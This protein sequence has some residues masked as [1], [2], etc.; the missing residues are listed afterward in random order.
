M[1][2]Q[3]PIRSFGRMRGR[4]LRVTKQG[5]M[6]DILP[7]YTLAMP[8]VV[9]K[10]TWLEIGFGQGE[11]LAMQAKRNP[12]VQLIGCEPFVNGIGELL[13]QIEQEHLDNI[14]IHT[15]DAREVMKALPNA[16]LSRAFI[17]FPDPWPKA[18]H[19]KRRIIQQE[20]LA[21]MARILKPGGSLLIATDHEDYLT[22][23]LERIQ[24]QSD[25]I[26][27]A[28]C[29][30]DWAEPPIDWVTTKYQAKAIREGRKPHWL[31]LLRA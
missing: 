12:D 28:Q 27:T 8:P 26:W 11:H 21:D 17:L 18:R 29:K 31:K 24:A 7:K 2:E 10:E 1:Q 6:A 19:H 13:R 22:W 3:L 4:K 20:L 30:A 14:R 25:F 9:E 23:I 15:H 16:S 5:L